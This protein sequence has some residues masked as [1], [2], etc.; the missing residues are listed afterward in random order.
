MTYLAWL[1]LISLAFVVAER[2]APRRDQALLRPGWIRDLGFLAVNGHLYSAWTGAL[3]ASMAMAATRALEAAGLRLPGPALGGW[4]V[5]VQFVVL[6]VAADFLQWCVHN[7]LHRV[8]ALWQFH[9]VHHSIDTMDWVGNWRFHWVEIVVYRTLLWL[10]LTLLGASGPAVMAAAIVGTVWGNLNHSNVDVRLGPLG[11]VFNSPRMHLWHHDASGEG[12][13]AKNFG[14][15]FSAWDFLFRTA[16]WP[17]DRD[18]ARLGYPGDEELP[19]DF[20][21]QMTWPLSDRSAAR[22]RSPART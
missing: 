5:A 6:L 19:D 9:K 3:N 10:P 4:P 1:A 2:L 13:R 18:P 17:R 14:I 20:L 11:Y 15:I 8:P 12:G 22:G 16:F 7:L 21:G